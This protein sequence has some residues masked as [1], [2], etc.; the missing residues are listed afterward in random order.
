MKHNVV[1]V[2]G[3]AVP[4]S[5]INRQPT[6]VMVGANAQQ[7]YVTV[8]Q[9]D[10]VPD[11][12]IKILE[13]DNNTKI[14]GDDV[15]MSSIMYRIKSNNINRIQVNMTKLAYDISNLKSIGPLYITTIMELITE[16]FVANPPLTYES[17]NMTLPYG[18]YYDHKNNN[19]YF[20]CLKLPDSLNIVLYNFMEF[21]GEKQSAKSQKPKFAKR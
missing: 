17:S 1:I 9:P 6:V 7:A 5:S 2:G 19:S 8:Q 18:G 14:T 3:P 15:T 4:L 20:D 10:N 21:V 11:P 13:F 16:Y 12:I